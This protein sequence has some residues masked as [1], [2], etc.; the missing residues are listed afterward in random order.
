M[1]Y[2]KKVLIIVLGFMSSS[3]GQAELVYLAKVDFA[4]TIFND[5][6][7]LDSF[8]DEKPQTKGS[9]TVPGQFTTRFLGQRNYY[10]AS[11]NISF[12]TTAIENGKEITIKGYIE[13]DLF[14]NEILTGYLDV[15]LNRGKDVVRAELSAELIYKDEK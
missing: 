8:I 5:L 10:K 2:L 6:L 1:N 3:I 9:L 7:V 13:E 4:G 12:S 15:Y 14:T 11:P